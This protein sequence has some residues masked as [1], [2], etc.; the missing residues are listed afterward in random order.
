MTSFFS[1]IE[2]QFS[3]YTWPRLIYSAV[4][5]PA[6]HLYFEICLIIGIIWLLFKRSYNIHDKA[7]L[8]AAEK[9]DL[10]REWIPEPLVPTSWVPSKKL[11]ERFHRASVGSIGKYVRFEGKGGEVT[12]SHLNVASL[13]FLDFIGDDKLNK[14]AIK[15]LRTYG[16]GA[17]G[18]RGFY[19]TFDAHL[20]L[21]KAIESFLG[22][23][24]VALYSYAFSTIASAIP[25]YAKRT[26]VIFADE[27]VGQAVREGLRASRSTVRYFRHNDINH[28]EEL[29]VAQEA[30][31]SDNPYRASQIRRFLVVEGLYLDYG[32]ICPLPHL[33]DLKYKYKVRIILDESIS[34]GVLGKTGRG[35]TEHFGIN[36]EHVDLITSSLETAIG[37]CGGFCAG[38]HF[39]VDHQRLSGQGYCFSASLP[40]MLAAAAQAAVE[41]LTSEDGVRQSQLRRLSHRL[42]AALMEAALAQFWS[43]EPCSHPDSPVKHIRLAVGAN[44]ME[45]LEYACDLAS[46]LSSVDASESRKEELGTTPVLLT[47]ARHAENTL[48]KVPEPSI[49]L[50]LNCS[51]TTAELDH[52]CK[53]LQK[54][55]EIMAGSESTSEQ[56]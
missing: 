12:P 23:E 45:R 27:G 36:V 40:P 28:L 22:V 9:E 2:D 20:T 46:T 32:D 7:K 43:L 49:R 17:C 44:S 35:V 15:A 38:S 47:V 53:M 34:F 11:L 14:V 48:R 3:E 6:Y 30:E 31:D 50:A 16:L 4:R 41:Q 26:D 56:H 10:I 24:E 5:V 42:Q 33:V 19:G 39:V 55:G 8:S 29:M 37:V 1:D 21:E 25:A 54:V 51:M 13:N 52:V 18:P